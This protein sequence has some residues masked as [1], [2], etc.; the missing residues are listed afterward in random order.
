MSDRLIEPDGTDITPRICY[1]CGFIIHGTY[2]DE[3]MNGRARR[4]RHPTCRL[5]N[6]GISKRLR[7]IRNIA[8]DW[9]K[10]DAGL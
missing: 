1:S 7:D 3:Q 9:V 4:F 2:V 8:G 6:D 10:E 5:N